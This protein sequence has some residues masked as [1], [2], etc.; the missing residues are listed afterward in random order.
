MSKT[1]AN[2]AEYNMNFEVG[3]SHWFNTLV[4]GI[5][6]M[7]LYLANNDHPKP[8]IVAQYGDKIQKSA[9]DLLEWREQVDVP[10]RY[11]D[12]LISQLENQLANIKE[13]KK[14]I[15]ID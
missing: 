14:S 10:N 7:G 11:A 1:F 6:N 3:S 13:Y 9:M 4:S 5:M 8:Y 2:R 12:S 15:S